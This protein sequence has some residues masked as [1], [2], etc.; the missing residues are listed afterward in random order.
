M[1]KV[2]Q[3]KE[4]EIFIDFANKMIELLSQ[5]L[6]EDIIA[7]LDDSRLSKEDIILALKYLDEELPVLKIDN[8]F[9][10]RCEKCRIEVFKYN[11]NSGYALDHDLSTNGEVNDLTLQLEFLQKGM[12][13]AVILDDIHTL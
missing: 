12:E 5:E 9:K 7:I 6:Y 8:P 4:E 3:G 1:I 11:D 2:E 13:Y 10:V